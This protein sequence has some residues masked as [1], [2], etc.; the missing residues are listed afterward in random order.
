VAKGA[1][2][3]DAVADLV[4][5]AG[6]SEDPAELARWSAS[7]A[8]RPAAEVL[9]LA[10]RRWPDIRF[11]TAFGPEGCLLIDLVARHRLP[12][13][14][15]TLDTGLLFP[16]TYALW[17]RLQDRYGL[18]IRPVRPSLSL[19]AQAA[20]FGE[21]L[22]ERD[23]DQCCA[24]RKIEPLRGAL[25]GAQAWV[26]SIRRDQTRDRSMAGLA[27]WDDRFALVK[28][29]PLAHWTS[30]AVWAYL[31]AH[32]VP[33]NP[34]LEQ[35][36]TSIGCMPCTTPVVAGES[37]RAGRWR[38]TEKTEC[39]LHNRPRPTLVPTLPSTG[40]AINVHVEP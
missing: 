19:A 11:S 32:D 33:V 12:I 37:A 16:E 21:R 38:G 6:V 4:V 13:D 25:E 24:L 2:V 8:G 1:G 22:W 17:Q 9:A 5:P 10:A 31:R 36:Y 34:L 30:A 3:V 15:F 35:G 14:I 7:L 26:T 18:T 28:V 23:P 20:R 27:E 39:G 29:N 40:E